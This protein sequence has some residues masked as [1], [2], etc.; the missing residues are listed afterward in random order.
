MASGPPLLWMSPALSG[1]GYSPEALA[2]AQGL[3]RRMPPTHFRLRQFAEQ[4]DHTFLNGLPTELARVVS[5]TAEAPNARRHKGVTVC[6][7]PPDAWK[8]SK[9]SILLFLS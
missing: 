8:P 2:F 4:P 7:A 3:A 9:F 5:A 6:H 1:G